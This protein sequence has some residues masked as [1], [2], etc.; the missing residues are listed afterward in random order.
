MYVVARPSMG[1]TLIHVAT[2]AL[3]AEGQAFSWAQD[4]SRTVFTID[5]RKKLV[6]T[7]AIPAVTAADPVVSLRFR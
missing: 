4:G 5:R 3:D 1:P 7:I 6:R 2:I